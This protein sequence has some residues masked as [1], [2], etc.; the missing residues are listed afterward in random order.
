MGMYAIPYPPHFNV[1]DARPCII[2]IQQG[3]ERCVVQLL[4]SALVVIF[5]ELFLLLLLLGLTIFEASLEEVGEYGHDVRRLPV[6]G[7]SLP[8]AKADVRRG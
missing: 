4:T 6:A 7:G 1:I 5:C 2:S 8:L 3:R